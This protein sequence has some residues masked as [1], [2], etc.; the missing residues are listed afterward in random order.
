MNAESRFC[1]PVRQRAFSLIEVAVVLVILTVLLTGLAMPIAAQMQ[2]RRHE[3]TRKL[4]E[5][6]RE[7]LLGFAAANGRLPCPSASASNGRE[8]FCTSSTG[9]CAPTSVPQA[10]GKCSTFYAGFLPGSTLGLAPLDHEGFVLDGWNSRLRY[11]VRDSGPE[12]ALT[13][14]GGIKAISMST[15]SD[16]D[17]LVLCGAAN[18]VTANSCGTST[19]LTD[20]APFLLMSTGPSP[21]SP[22]TD[23]DEAENLDGDL[24][25]ISHG[26]TAEFDD[27][28][29]WA[30]LHTLFSRMIA[31][32]K[33]P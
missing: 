30:S 25:F 33:L 6:A 21:Q 16:R 23:P 3:E 14:A 22:S 1:R 13:A 8:S 31:A 28:V 12:H 11:A 20:K 29:T 4:M 2:M 5:E 17:Y 27:V 32:G 15:L 26:L 7:A 19:L 10:H 18:G 24:V 9:G